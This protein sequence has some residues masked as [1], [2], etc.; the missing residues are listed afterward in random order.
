MPADLRD[1]QAPEELVAQ[2]REALGG[3]DTLVLN[4]QQISCAAIEE[5]PMEQVIDTFHVNIIAM[6]G[7]VSKECLTC[8]RK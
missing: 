5:L 7:I 8:C 6:F 4:A 1:K 3:L 2:A